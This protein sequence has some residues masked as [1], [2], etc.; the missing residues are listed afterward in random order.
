MFD[1]SFMP[2]CKNHHNDILHFARMRYV[3]T[4]DMY[5]LGRLGVFEAT[6]DRDLYEYLSFLGS[7]IVFLIDWNWS[8]KIQIFSKTRCIE[9]LKWVD[10]NYGYSAFLKGGGSES[11]VRDRIRA[12]LASYFRT[13]E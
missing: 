1:C 9:I 8:R 3:S 13:A 12:E 5:H 6:D 11:L 7:R 10:K 4:T 2:T